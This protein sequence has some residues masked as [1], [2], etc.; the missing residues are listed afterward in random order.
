M[1]SPCGPP[2]GR[3][4]APVG[5]APLVS[6]GTIRALLQAMAQAAPHRNGRPAYTDFW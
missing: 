5:E 4:T 1:P 3:R 2:P 6:H